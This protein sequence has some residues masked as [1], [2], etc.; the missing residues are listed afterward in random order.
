MHRIYFDHSATTPTDQRVQKKMTSYSN[1]KFGN[2]SSVHSF[3]QAAEAAVN[4]ARE[5]TADFLN[6]H[7]DE[8]IF[9][10][11]ATESDNLAVFGLVQALK[12]RGLKNIH[13]VTSTIEH[14]AV[15]ECFKSLAERN[16]AQVT[17]VPVDEKGVVKF[18]KLKE[19]IQENTVF[20]S[21]MYVNSEVG[22]VQPIERIGKL[23]KEIKEKRKQTDNKY[24]LYFHTDAVQAANYFSCDVKKLGVN[25][26]SLSGHKIYGPKGVG[27]LFVEKG[28]PLS[29]MQ[30]GGHQ[31]RGM[32][33]GTSNV[34]GIVGMAEALFWAKKERKENCKKIA[35]LRDLLA[36]EIEKNIP[37]IKSNTDFN[38]ASPSHANFCFL[39]TEGEAVLLDLDFEGVAVSTGS[40]CA[41]DNLKASHVLLAMGILEETA[42]SAI[43]FTLGKYNTEK[44]IEKTARILPSIIERLKKMAPE[45]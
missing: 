1:V 27:V 31:E 29:P 35:R 21:V 5:K 10:S 26:M 7:K 40:A 44:E 18:G 33:S 38:N 3:G 17:Y 28:V 24:P 4:E 8:I 25:M 30:L 41:S 45:L 20:V 9:T 32:R 19:S 36:R 6:C 12:T 37:E 14:P 23:T 11:G 39:G 22:S 43:R 2:S 42:H 16:E 34:P 13:I 15:L